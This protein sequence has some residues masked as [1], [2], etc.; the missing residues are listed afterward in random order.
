[1]WKRAPAGYPA[2]AHPDR[3]TSEAR[4]L[5]CRLKHF[6]GRDKVS[7]AETLLPLSG[8]GAPAV[9]AERPDQHLPATG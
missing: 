1:M 7:I 9:A 8:A 2:W 6:L 4:S 5:L 3:S